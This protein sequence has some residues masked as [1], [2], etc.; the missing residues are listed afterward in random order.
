MKNLHITRTFFTSIFLGT[1]CVL[2]Q[3]TQTTQENIAEY[4]QYFDLQKFIVKVTKNTQT[5]NPL[6]KK[7]I[8]EDE[9][10]ITKELHIKSWDNELRLFLENNLNKPSLFGE[11]E[12]SKNDKEEVYTAK[13]K[14][15]HTRKFR[16]QHISPTQKN[17]EIVYEDNNYLYRAQR[18]LKIEVENDQVK[19]YHIK[20]SQ[21][22]I[23]IADRYYDIKGEVL[24]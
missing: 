13:K 17:I 16:L 6:V 1:L 9:E 14:S 23:W 24:K 19:N 20:G 8:I 22:G 15:L 21:T 4:K 7:T 5:K 18:I 11:Y 3:C 12:T 10:S 2:T